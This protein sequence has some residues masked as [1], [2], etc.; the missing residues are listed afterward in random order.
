ME[1]RSDIVI[2]KVEKRDI[3]ILSSFVFVVMLIYNFG[4]KQMEFG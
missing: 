1:D 2:N 4:I 3:L